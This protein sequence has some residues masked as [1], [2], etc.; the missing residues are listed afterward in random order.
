M[1]A[2]GDAEDAASTLKKSGAVL[3]GNPHVLRFLR[4]SGSDTLLNPKKNIY[5]YR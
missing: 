5:I 1:V 3:M 4:R 2:T